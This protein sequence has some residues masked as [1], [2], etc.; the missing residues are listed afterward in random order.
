MAEP[1]V[2]EVEDVMLAFPATVIGTLLPKWKDI[3]DEFKNRSNKWC[4]TA[5]RFF[6]EGTKEMELI[7]K[8]G[9][10]VPKALRHVVACLRSY[11]PKHEHKE[12]GVAYLLA[13]FFE[14][15]K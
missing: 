8:E 1:V 3:P 11:E 4:R 2:R 7:P 5:S 9:I 14:D 15:V 10:D 12:A 6:F 13:T